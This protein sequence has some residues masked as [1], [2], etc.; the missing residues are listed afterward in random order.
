VIW[1]SWKRRWTREWWKVLNR[2]EVWLKN[3]L[4]S[5]ENSMIDSI[6]SKWNCLEKQGMKGKVNKIKKIVC[7]IHLN[8]SL[9]GRSL[10]I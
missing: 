5:R 7:S 9:I 1:W 2:L 3:I 10:Q 4:R 6:K 8:K